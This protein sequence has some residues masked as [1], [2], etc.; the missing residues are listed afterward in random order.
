MMG[1]RTSIPLLATAILL[2]APAEAATSYYTGETAFNSAVGGLTLLDPGL[3]FSSGDLAPGGLYNASGTGIDFLGLDNLN[4][5]LDF[6]VSSGSLIATAAGEQVTVNLPAGVYA[7]G[8]HISVAPAS[9]FGNWCL[10]LTFNACDANVLTTNS[11]VTAFLGITS[12][13]PIAGPIYIHAL[14]GSPSMVIKDFAAYSDPVPETNTF[15]LVGLGLVI[16][17]IARRRVR[18][19]A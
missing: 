17:P 5:P 11:T 18:R 2:V 8:I 12:T 10:E 14:T 16:L 3:T 4:S 9:S 19:G 1:L 6:T 13:T 7:F 15:L